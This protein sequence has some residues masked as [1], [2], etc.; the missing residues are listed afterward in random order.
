MKP[1]SRMACGFAVAACFAA[2]VACLAQT[3]PAKPIR[4]VLTYAGSIE[5]ATRLVAQKMSEGL[6]Q[7]VVLDSQPGAAGSIGAANVARAVPDGYTIL[8]STGSTQFLLRLLTKNVPYDPIRDFTPIT[9]GWETITVLVTSK[10]YPLNS[11]QELIEY[12]KRNPGKVSYGTSGN[13]TTHHFSLELIKQLTGV[14][15]V[16][17][18]YKGGAQP[19]IDVIAGRIEVSSS[20]L[21]S[22]A[23]FASSGKIKYFAVV[24]DRRF[25]RI[26]DVPSVRE[27][28]PGFRSPPF[29]SAFYGPPGLPQTVVKRLNA[30][31]VR[32]L[33]LPDVRAKLGELGMLVVASTPEELMESTRAGIEASDRIAKAAHLEPQD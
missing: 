10:A 2:P 20:V 25:D 7:P 22:V 17:I 14:D 28:I 5:G 6:G 27:V 9:L 1:F 16:H 4:M 32:V 26:P 18:P 13:G 24:N 21:A 29:W 23:P 19:L 31:I 15:I 8:S 3:Y 11:L 30:E 12:A 33:K